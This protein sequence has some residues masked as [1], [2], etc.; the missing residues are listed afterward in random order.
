M[1]DPINVNDYADNCI[2]MYDYGSESEGSHT[3]APYKSSS[4]SPDSLSEDYH[5]I[6]EPSGRLPKPKPLPARMLASWNNKRKQ[7][8][9]AAEDSHGHP[10]KPVAID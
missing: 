3:Y 6:C 2:N 5:D 8:A 4:P 1:D 10:K 7:E 9:T